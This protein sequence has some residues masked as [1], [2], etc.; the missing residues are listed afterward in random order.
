M[1]ATMSASGKPGGSDQGDRPPQFPLDGGYHKGATAYFRY[2][3]QWGKS[4]EF[5]GLQ[6]RRKR[7]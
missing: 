4:G 7:P 5:A 6:F 2:V 3:D 1:P